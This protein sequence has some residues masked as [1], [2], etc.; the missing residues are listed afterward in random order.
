[1]SKLAQVRRDNLL[2]LITERYEANHSLFAKA[3]SMSKQQLSN[4]VAGKD[5]I[6]NKIAARIEKNNNLRHGWLNE[7]QRF[8]R[9]SFDITEDLMNIIEQVYTD[10]LK[11]FVDH[12][13]VSIHAEHSVDEL[14]TMFRT[15]L[16]HT[17]SDIETETALAS[18]SAVKQH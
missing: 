8:Y 10:T 18:A 1:M 16:G 6:G 17:L 13:R 5:N 4:L 14:G 9:Q 12:G 7:P 2:L 15:V 3:N 11:D